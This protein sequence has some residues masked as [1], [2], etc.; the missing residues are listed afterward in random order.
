[1]YKRGEMM[2]VSFE[3]HPSKVGEKNTSRMQNELA[4]LAGKLADAL[5]GLSEESSARKAA[6]AKLA[7]VEAQMQD[8]V[9]IAV[10]DEKI[11]NL[12]ELHAQFMK[13]MQY[14]AMMARGDMSSIMPPPMQSLSG[15]SITSE[16]PVAGS[17]F[18][19]TPNL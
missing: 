17:S 14:G 19:L 11:K 9:A 5:K 8:A 7:A 18:P 16:S 2:A 6:E 10:K 13:G 4:K 1:M 12:S 15:S 3:E